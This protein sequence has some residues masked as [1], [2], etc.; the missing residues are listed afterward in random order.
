MLLLSIIILLSIILHPANC[1]TAFTKEHSHTLKALLPFGVIIHHFYK[2]HNVPFITDDTQ[3][4]GSYIVAIFFF[5]SGYGLSYKRATK[6]DFLGMKQL[7]MQINRLLVPLFLVAILY[8]SFNY[9]LNGVSF[10]YMNAFYNWMLGA[11]PLP[12][13]WFVM[14][15]IS[16]LFLYALSCRFKRFG[17]GI[18]C[19]FFSYI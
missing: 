9:W 16:L 19:L 13:T 6:K 15:Y 11:P 3:S 17:G 8:H 5:I 2:I 14:T 4:L 18:Y 10:D 1:I 7:L 12:Y